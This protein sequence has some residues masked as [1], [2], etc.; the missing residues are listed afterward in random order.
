MTALVAILVVLVA[1]GVWQLLVIAN[2]ASV[3]R[4]R[5]NEIEE[6]LRKKLLQ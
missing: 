6:H 2:A 3:I 5:L 1:M 4:D